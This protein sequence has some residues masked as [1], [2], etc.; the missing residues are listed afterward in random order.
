M[1]SLIT[2]FLFI[3]S[4]L[5]ELQA[6]R[7]LPLGTIIQFADLETGRKLLGSAD[8]YTAKWSPFDI[9]S[10]LQ[11]AEGTREELISFGAQQVL[12][13]TVDEEQRI[14]TILARIDSAIRVNNYYWPL[15]EKIY[16]LKSTLLEEGG[17]GGYTRENYIVL[18]EDLIF[19]DEH[20]LQH[21]VLHEIFHILTRHDAAYRKDFYNVIG[22]EVDK[23]LPF[24]ET[25]A[26]LRITNPDAHAQDSYI[27]LTAKD[28]SVFEAV[29]IIYA[30]QPWKGGIFF[31][32]LQLGLA[33][34]EGE[35]GNKQL[36]LVN[37]RP[38][39]RSIDETTDFMDKV[40]RNT[41]YILDPEEIL[42]DNFAHVV[43][44]IQGKPDT[45]IYDEIR[46]ILQN[47]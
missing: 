23:P 42:A 38:V 37:G 6:H 32:Y 26:H 36:K 18:R 24:P 7:M 41:Q 39:I 10:R 33:E 20:D 35:P 1:K 47:H 30:N 28:S 34:I 16:L 46:S 2:I 14:R 12:E 40:G 5:P 15:P 45:W 9:Q 4:L 13:W 44:N 11:Q 25:I 8:A 29:M 27:S 19:R 22:F 31:Q 43:M 17:A 21:I 3:L